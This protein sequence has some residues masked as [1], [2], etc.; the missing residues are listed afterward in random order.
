MIVVQAA[1]P[2]RSR[3][4]SK[5]LARV[6]ERAIA[7]S[8]RRSTQYGGS[9]IR[10][11]DG[12]I[13]YPCRIDIVRIGRWLIKTRTYTLVNLLSDARGPEEH[14]A[15]EFIPWYGSTAPVA[16]RALDFLEHPEKM[17]AQQG[18]LAALVQKLDHPGASAKV[19]D[20]ALAMLERKKPQVKERV[21]L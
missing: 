14:I 17:R 1:R 9:T 5:S 7:R 20:M 10:R 19:A 18:R 21:P 3:E 8:G 2:A 6:K 11:A 16:E 13:A 15:P 12:E 4:Q